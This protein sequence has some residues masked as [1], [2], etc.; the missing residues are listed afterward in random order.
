MLK[1]IAK[2][3]KGYDRCCFNCELKD[4]CDEV[5]ALDPKKCEYIRDTSEVRAEKREKNADKKF[6]RLYII[7][8]ILTLS[9]LIIGLSIIGKQNYIM[10]TDVLN[11]Q[12]TIMVEL[13]KESIDPAAENRS[14]GESEALTGEARDIIERV[15]AAEARGEDL[16]TMMAV[17][18]VIKDRSDLWGMHPVDVVFADGQFAKP[19]EG[20]ISEKTGK[21]GKAYPS[22]VVPIG[23]PVHP[24]DLDFIESIINIVAVVRALDDFPFELDSSAPGIGSE[25]TFP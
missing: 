25:V 13:D 16:Q 3:S 2:C 19:Y 1:C 9:V 22:M 21:R 15:V 20:E 4:L 23:K 11:N 18:Q 6:W 8:F 7:L 14:E 17:A 5:C 24:E 10:L 12:N